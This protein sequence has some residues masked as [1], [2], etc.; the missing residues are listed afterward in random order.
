M[1]STSYNTHQ[2][3]PAG[4]HGMGVKMHSPLFPTALDL[5]P[6][7]LWE[8][9]LQSP[10]VPPP[11]T[12][13]H[14][15]ATPLRASRLFRTPTHMFQGSPVFNYARMHLKPGNLTHDLQAEFARIVGISAGSD[16][17]TTVLALNRSLTYDH[18]AKLLR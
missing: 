17:T 4:A 13:L 18:T 7:M 10:R 2:V 1:T 6:G 9:A 3:R 16:P 11:Q 15:H 12:N 14:E 5:I 8:E